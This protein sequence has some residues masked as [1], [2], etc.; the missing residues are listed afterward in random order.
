MQQFN[1]IFQCL[2]RSSIGLIFIA[3]A[4]HA[5][6]ADVKGS[7][8]SSSKAALVEVVGDIIS[9]DETKLEKLLA[10]FLPSETSYLHVYI[11]VVP[12]AKLL[13]S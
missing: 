10:A 3:T 11:R 9:G 8:Y 12:G 1:L 2:L 7:L 13:I 6:A 4:T 5:F